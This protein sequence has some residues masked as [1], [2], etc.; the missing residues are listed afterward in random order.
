MKIRLKNINLL[1]AYYYFRSVYFQYLIE[2]NYKGLQNNNIFPSQIQEFPIPAVSLE[3]QNDI[4]EEIK[5][6]IETQNKTKQ[7]ILELRK[8]IDELMEET[9]MDIK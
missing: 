1:Y 7:E 3:Q 4:V 8:R 6:A 9:I 5:Q 2:I